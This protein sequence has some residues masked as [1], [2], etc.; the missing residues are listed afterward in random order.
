M[1][2][3]RSDQNQR[4]QIRTEHN[5]ADETRTDQTVKLRFNHVKFQYVH[6]C[7][8]D[9]SKDQHWNHH[10]L[11]QY[12]HGAEWDQWHVRTGCPRQQRRLKTEKWVSHCGLNHRAP[13]IIL[14]ELIEYGSRRIRLFQYLHV[15]SSPVG[16]FMHCRASDTFNC[17]I[18]C[19]DLWKHDRNRFELFHQSS[20]KFSFLPFFNCHLFVLFLFTH[21]P[22]R[23]WSSERWTI[24]SQKTVSCGECEIQLPNSVCYLQTIWMWIDMHRNHI[25]SRV[26]FLSLNA[27]KRGDMKTWSFSEIGELIGDSQ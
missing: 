23:P 13:F 27:G 3:F 19:L 1:T 17:R 9:L 11:I 8:V 20:G 10:R 26:Q 4:E 15:A 24:L 21:E 18:P 2:L 5:E 7:N 16:G 6:D 14:F 12:Q 25:A 22:N